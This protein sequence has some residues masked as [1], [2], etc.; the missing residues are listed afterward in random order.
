MSDNTGDYVTYGELLQE[1][2]LA[3]S[4]LVTA[5]D[6]TLSNKTVDAGG[7]IYEYTMASGSPL[8]GDVI[9]QAGET[10]CIIEILTTPNRIRIEKTD[11]ENLIANGTAKLLHSDKVYKKRGLELIHQAMDFIDEKTGQFFNKRTGTFDI[12]GNNTNTLFLNVPIIEITKFLINSSDVE[13]SEGIDYDFVAFKGRARPQDNRRNP[14]IKLNFG[15]ARNSIYANSL[16]NRYFARGTFQTIEGSFG[17]L[18][19]DGTTPSLIKKATLILALRD[20]NAPLAGSSTSGTVGPLKR[21]KVDLHEE[22]FFELKGQTSKGTLSGNEEV[23][24]IIANYKSPIGIGG[25]F[26][27]LPEYEY[28]EDLTYV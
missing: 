27:R 10:D 23:D 11:A 22:E 21:Q 24:R 1:L 9:S 15:R 16:T 6:I 28:R 13:I 3:D 26:K 14:M 25:S 7:D 12:E 18:E 17:F 5:S 4:T 2:Y 19:P 20:V 8:V